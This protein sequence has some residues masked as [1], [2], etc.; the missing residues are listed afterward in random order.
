MINYFGGFK[1]FLYKSVNS[2]GG[3]DFFAWEE[4]DLFKKWFEWI[5]K[6]CGDDYDDDD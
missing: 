2:C 6:C 3:S 4:R 5:P 1:N